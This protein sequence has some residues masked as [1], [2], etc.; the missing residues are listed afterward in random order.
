MG[1]IFPS[2]D[3]S[4]ATHAEDG[5]ARARG[6]GGVVG[7]VAPVGADVV[8]GGGVGDVVAGIGAID[9]LRIVTGDEALEERVSVLAVE[10]AERPGAAAEL[11]SSFVLA[12]AVVGR[13]PFVVARS[14]DERGQVDGVAR[15]EECAA[16][17]IELAQLVLGSQCL[18]SLGHEDIVTVDTSVDM[19]VPP[20]DLALAH[21]NGVG[22]EVGE[23]GVERTGHVGE[24]PLAGG[25]G[26]GIEVV[27]AGGCAHEECLG[28]VDGD[29]GDGVGA[30][31][32]IVLHFIGDGLREVLCLP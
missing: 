24:H 31:G 27:H 18:G 12:P 22:L 1:G 2:H 28:L 17:L 9:F 30:F 20:D 4:V 19:E 25:L 29:D 32:R 15:Q 5:S 6:P 3:G 10:D 21:V 16:V 8:L 26:L 23:A 11:G 14:S 7:I 13:G